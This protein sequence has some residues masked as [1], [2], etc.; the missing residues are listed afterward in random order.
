MSNELHINL[1]RLPGANALARAAAIAA[2]QALPEPDPA[3]T[4][5]YRSEGRVL[6]AGS[7]A[8]VAHWAEQLPPPLVASLACVRSRADIEI[9]GY[10]GAF[11]VRWRSGNAL[12]EGQFDLI[13]DLC[14]PPLLARHTLPHGYFAPGQNDE[15]RA[16]VIGELAGMTGVF[17]K[18]KYFVYRAAR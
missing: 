10:L 18:P 16:A 7:A 2:A 12:L 11:A 1:R 4:V 6:V 8:D 9:A 14:D 13:L 5:S 3:P 17:E 15:A